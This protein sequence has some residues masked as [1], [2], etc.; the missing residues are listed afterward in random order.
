MV[1]MEVLLIKEYERYDNVSNVQPDRQSIHWCFRLLIQDGEN[2]R[3]LGYLQGLLRTFGK[4]L[5]P[6]DTNPELGRANK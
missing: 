5:A 3:T 4:D 1:S 2:G 6:Y